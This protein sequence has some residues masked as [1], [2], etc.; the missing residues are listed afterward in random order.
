M[1]ARTNQFEVAAQAQL[2]FQQLEI[3]KKCLEIRY[4]V[5][6]LVGTV[7]TAHQVESIALDVLTQAVFILAREVGCARKQLHNECVHIFV[8][9]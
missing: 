6:V 4:F 9:R 5:L 7:N 3:V 8:D 1:F 2:Q